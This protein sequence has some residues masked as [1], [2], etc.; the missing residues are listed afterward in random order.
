MAFRDT[1]YLNNATKSERQMIIVLAMFNRLGKYD[2]SDK[3]TTTYKNKEVINLYKMV[4]EERITKT[5]TLYN[6]YGHIHTMKQRINKIK[7]KQNKTH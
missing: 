3:F 5:N 4:T 6:I 1:G 2:P 7:G